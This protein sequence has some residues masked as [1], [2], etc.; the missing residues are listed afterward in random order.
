MFQSWFVNFDPVRAKAVS[1]PTE[2]ICSRLKLSAD[3]LALFPDRFQ[4]SSLGEIP[5]GWSI[6]TVDDLSLKVGMGPF[7]SNI[8]VSTFV[9]D[10]I[11]VISGQHLNGA[12]LED[13]TFNFIT[14]DHA[15]KLNSSNVG[16]GDVVFTHAGNIGQVSYVPD[17]SR[18]ARYVLSQ[19]QFFL[20][21]DLTKISPIFMVYFFRS[22][23]GQHRLLA[24]A[25]QV[26][27]PSIARPATYLKSIQLV[28]PSKALSDEFDSTARLLHRRISNTRIETK[29]LG[30]IRDTLLPK[31]LSGE[32]RAPAAGVV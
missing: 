7:G 21:C 17:L 31:L 2:A 25:S 9:E 4:H 22:P 28:V 11:P 20:R 29:T 8:K 15:D 10:G 26:G 27:V 1:E 19:R 12:L 14:L 23:Q 18:Y 5:A 24:N 6:R 16:R 32:L 30:E 3:L 13:T